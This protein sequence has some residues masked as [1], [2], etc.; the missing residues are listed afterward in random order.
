M[1]VLAVLCCLINLT[2]Q[3]TGGSHRISREE[4]STMSEYLASRTSRMVPNPPPAPVRTMAEWEEL[5][6]LIISWAGQNT[7][8]RE[9]VRNAVKECRVFILTNNPTTVEG[10][11]TN[12]GI[13]LDSV[14][15]LDEPFNTIWVR[16][17]GPWT[18]YKNDVD[19]LWIVDWIYN[20]PREDD[21]AVPTVIANHLNIPIFEATAAPFDWVH[22]GG[23]HLPDG[24]GTVFSSELV[25]EE[26]PEKSEAQ[27]DS[28]AQAYLGVKQYIKLPTLP[29][30]GIH[31]LDMHMRIIDE[32]TILIGQYPEG[33]ADGPQIEANIQY[34]M[35]SVRTSFGNPYKIVRL[36]MPP[37]ANGRYPNT[38]GNYRT[39][40]NSVFV[41]KTILVPTYEERYDTTALRI[42]R[43]NLP[44]YTVV[45]IN[46]NSI[47]GQLGAI[48]CITK[49]VGVDEPLLIAHARLRDVQD[50]VLE[51]PLSA[52]IRH[53]DGIA[54]AS[55][56][57]RTA[58]DSTYI[59][60][61]MTLT[62]T[63]GNIWSVIIPGH[64]G[65]TEIHYYIQATATTGK[66]Q[67]RPLVAPEGYFR[68][69]VLEEE[70]IANLPP[71]VRIIDPIDGATFPLSL[72]SIPITVEATDA[73]G[74]VVEVRVVVSFD[75]I[76]S[77]DSLPYVADWTFNDVGTF[78]AHAS[79]MDD[80]SVIVYSEPIVIHIEDATA[81]DDVTANRIKLYPNPTNSVLH[82]ESDDALLPAITLM[83]AIGHLIQPVIHNEGSKATVDLSQVGP[84]L[85]VVKVGD[86]P[87]KI[88]K[89]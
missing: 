17:Y 9:I 25:F 87:Y 67:V 64:V 39:Y 44:G 24:M 38:G 61:P 35:D 46:C 71:T 77:I 22:T 88:I 27:I 16:D 10:Q 56:F 6:G 85:Y 62:D 33:I 50:T 52:Y 66:T 81:T 45:G 49:T 7:I 5:Q 2:A 69:N 63:L 72:G 41:N 73:D 19:S 13:P 31:H 37:D 21:D 79:A 1:T 53:R 74:E 80:D 42:Y 36:P 8:L 20:R 26:N 86:V 89:H 58:D 78:F 29:F 12:A 15:F 60:L 68:F 43:E 82:I 30:D 70:V 3:D 18:V 34:I 84:G 51:Y 65:K 28:I 83:N 57:Y 4:R 48:H 55:I 23:N 11:L 75:E 76:A 54:T 47:I 32:E 59:E 14:T 40:T